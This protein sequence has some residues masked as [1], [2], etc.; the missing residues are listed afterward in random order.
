MRIFLTLLRRELAAFFYSLAGYI[1]IAAVTLLVGQGFMVVI[2]NLGTDASPMPVTEL[3]YGTYYFWMIVLLAAPVMTMRLFALE[4][5]S[6]TFETLMTT[7]IS[8]VQ[9]VAAKFF[10]AMIFYLIAWLP[11]LVCLY[12][13]GHF[14]RQIG[15]DAGTVGGMFLGIFLIGCLFLS[16]GCFA[17]AIT[18]SQMAAAMVSFVLGM[19]LF[20]LAFLAK[21]LPPDSD[22]TQIIPYFNLFDQMDGFARGVVDTRVIV[23]YLSASFFFLFLTLRV[24]ESRR[25]K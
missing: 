2:Q 4:K 19:S 14:S 24:V 22:L 18:N 16:L 5:A 17:S 1:I 11:L 8:D 9:V 10:A 21:A 3:F 13:V 23:F 7:Q 6:G 15:L 12:I 20:S 25:W